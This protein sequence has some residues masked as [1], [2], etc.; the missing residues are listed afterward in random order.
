MKQRIRSLALW[1]ALAGGLNLVWEIIQLPLYTIYYETDLRVV[2]SAVVHCTLGDALI[3]LSSY[4]LAAA[5]TRSWDWPAHR[6]VPGAAIA[7]IAGLAYTAFSEWLNVSVRGSWT[8]SPAMPQLFGV[9]LS[10]LLQWLV[11]PL[12]GLFLFRVFRGRLLD[13][14]QSEAGYRH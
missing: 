2:T 8:Y 5:V 12:L 14:D 10:P 1:T 4:L 6:A 7:V 13:P 3:A 9:G 11:L